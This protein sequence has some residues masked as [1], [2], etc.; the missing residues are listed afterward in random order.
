MT[1]IMQSHHAYSMEHHFENWNEKK[2]CQ[3]D[4]SNTFPYNGP[5]SVPFPHLPCPHN[6]LLT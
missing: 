5:H 6:I 1:S 4:P 2:N 3:S